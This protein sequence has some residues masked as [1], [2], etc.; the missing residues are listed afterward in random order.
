[1]ENERGVTI[2]VLL[3]CLKI[4]HTLIRDRKEGAQVLSFSTINIAANDRLQ[5]DERGVMI[6][7]LL[8][9]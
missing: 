7:F 1:M 4:A 3:L 6:S 9:H 5:E 2:P 8:H